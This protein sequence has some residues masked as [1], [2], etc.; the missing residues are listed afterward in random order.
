MNV[1]R[2]RQYE[3]KSMAYS[4]TLYADVRANQ[5]RYMN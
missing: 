5:Y 4:R 3:R 2:K 1:G